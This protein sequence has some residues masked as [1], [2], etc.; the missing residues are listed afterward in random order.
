MLVTV[1]H[2]GVVNVILASTETLILICTVVDDHPSN[3]WLSGAN[4]VLHCF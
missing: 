3:I 2:V 4:S 1:C